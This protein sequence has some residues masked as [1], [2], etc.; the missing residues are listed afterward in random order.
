MVYCIFSAQYLPTVGGVERYTHELARCLAK[1][2]HSVL[3]VTASLPGLPAWEQ[4]SPAIEIFRVSSY[5][6]LQGRMPITL[7]LGQLQQTLRARAI[8]R[9]VIQT[10]LYPLCL[11]GMRFARKFRIPFLTIEHGS[12]YI[13]FQ[14][15]VLGLCDRIYE[16]VCLL[17]AKRWCRHFFSVSAASAAWLLQHDV[18]AEGVLYNSVDYEEIQQILA[19]PPEPLPSLPP[20]AYL[21]L[22]AGRLLPE[23]GILQLARAVEA[24]HG[25]GNPVYL[26]A[27]GDGPLFQPLMQLQFHS[28]RLLGSLPRDV[29]LRLMARCQVLCLP[30]DSEGFPTCVAEAVVCRCYVITAPYGGAKELIAGPA[31]GTV[32]PG[33]SQAEIEAALRWAME[34]PDACRDAAQNATLRFFHHFTWDHTCEKLEQAFSDFTC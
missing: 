19:Q 25:Q 22:F 29:L 18:R 2:G 11:L 13:G 21:V 28:L 12:G 14:N 8:D 10:R 5:S 9:I 27:A 20:S 15:P 26:L 17:L 7:S 3:I 34:H 1:R 24:L 33:N 16:N 31:Y 23:K 6:A 32:M 30:S 4:E